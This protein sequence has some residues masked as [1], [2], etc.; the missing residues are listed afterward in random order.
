MTDPVTITLRVAANDAAWASIARPYFAALIELRRAID[1][2]D[3]PA[4]AR[5]A[6]TL[7]RHS[8]AGAALAAREKGM[9][10]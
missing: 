3:G 5:A 9:Q 2:G 8:D 1:Q 6:R 10:P 4:A 7:E